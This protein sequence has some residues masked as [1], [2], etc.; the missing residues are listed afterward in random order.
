MRDMQKCLVPG[1]RG[2]SQESEFLQADGALETGHVVAHSLCLLILHLRTRNS[3][4]DH[5]LQIR[6]PG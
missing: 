2:P 5:T 1:P 3:L 4:L 6:L